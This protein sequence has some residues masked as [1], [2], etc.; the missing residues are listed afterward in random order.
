MSKYWCWERSD[1]GK[2]NIAHLKGHDAHLRAIQSTAR[3]EAVSSS[4]E[5]GSHRDA[6]AKL[7]EE[8][9]VKT[10][11]IEGKILNR[12]SVRASIA[13]KLGIGAIANIA[14]RDVDGLIETLTDSTQNF[15]EPLTHERLF[16]W[17]A[18]LFPA[19]RDEKGFP[20]EVGSYRT[21]KET[22]KVVSI[23]GRKETVHYIAP[24]SEAVSQEMDQFIKWFNKTSSKPN[25]IRAALASYWFVSIHPFEDG[26]GRISRAIA[27]M[28]VAQVESSPYRL[29]SMSE[30]LKS[31]ANFS[32]RYYEN[33]EG[34]SRGEKPIDEW[35]IFFLDALHHSAIRAELLLEDI[36]R[37]TAFWDKHFNSSFNGR[38]KKFLNMVLDKGRDFDGHIKR[39]RY[40]RFVGGISEATAKRDLQDLSAKG[41]ILPTETKGRN[42]GY[43][44][45]EI[46]QDKAHAAPT[47]A[48]Q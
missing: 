41:I 1:W 26:N 13:K 2:W 37:K 31:S 9:A 3:I 14:T 5:P 10:S 23:S 42:A 12:D 8:E 17:Q 6:E 46:P 33:L 4:L 48:P 30:T 7:L 29:F 39:Q 40:R 43:K 19:A 18:S 36:L 11:L 47:R 22:M 25:L 45:A 20:V 24:P 32:K 44:L 35:V 16:R 34:C 38:Q 27:D 28:A 15:A 21:S